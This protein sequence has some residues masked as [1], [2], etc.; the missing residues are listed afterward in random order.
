MNE[1]KKVQL[2][3]IMFMPCRIYSTSR[4]KTHSFN[5]LNIKERKKRGVKSLQTAIFIDS[6]P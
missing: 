2:L 4:L 1:P 6:S 3:D 5:G